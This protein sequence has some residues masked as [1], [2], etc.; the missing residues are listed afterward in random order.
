MTETN[1]QVPP[2][3]KARLYRQV[4][5]ATAGLS[6]LLLVMLVVGLALWDNDDVPGWTFVIAA[7]ISVPAVV[8]FD[9]GQRRRIR[10]DDGRTPTAA[11]KALGRKWLFWMSA[12]LVAAL[13]NGAVTVAN[14]VSDYTLGPW[15]FIVLGLVLLLMVASGIRMAQLFIAARNLAKQEA[16]K[17]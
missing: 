8:L 2:L 4:S 5:W 6:V 11:Q 10:R 13:V 14:S 9:F 7:G 12:L 15:V 3:D 1:E 17:K 16:Q